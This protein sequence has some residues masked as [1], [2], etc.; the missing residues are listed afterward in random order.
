MNDRLMTTLQE[1]SPNLLRLFCGWSPDLTDNSVINFCKSHPSL[2]RLVVYDAKKLTDASVETAAEHCPDLEIFLLDGWDLLTDKALVAL[3][4]LTR[5]RSLTL[6][7][8]LGYTNTSIA[9]VV[10]N[11][12]GMKGL[13]L[14]LRANARYDA[15]VFRYVAGYCENLRDIRIK[16]K[17]PVGSPSAGTPSLPSALLPIDDDL[18]PL[19]RTCPLLN[20]ID[21]D[22]A[23]Q[24]TERLLIELGSNCPN[25]TSVK[26]GSRLEDA[27]HTLVTDEGVAALAAGCPKLATLSIGICTE[28]TDE[29]ILAVA[30]HCKDLAC[31]V[32]SDNDKITDVGLRALFE[33]CTE[34]T[35]FEA[36]KLSNLTDEGMLALALHCHE[37]SVL[38][39]HTMGV[40]DA[41]LPGMGKCIRDLVT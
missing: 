3:A 32:L 34:L 24:L 36:T 13:I 14:T 38:R 17:S 22:C 31:I 23:S 18:I 30:Q 16:V 39:L 35:T 10:R 27:A 29:G 33:S 21:I 19:I 12:P 26:L 2:K 5:L 8:N 15:R 7:G 37:L 28:L 25:L 20:S 11:N 9:N 40:T 41:F 6:T 1:H 4:K